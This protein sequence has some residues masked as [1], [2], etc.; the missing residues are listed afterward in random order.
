MGQV[1]LWDH[2]TTGGGA[3]RVVGSLDHR[4]WVCGITGPQG[5]GQVG[6]WGRWTTGSGAGRVVGSLDHRGWGR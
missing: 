2:W 6:L 5:V 3:G 1:G 4:E